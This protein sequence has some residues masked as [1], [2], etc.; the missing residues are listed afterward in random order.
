[1]AP[2]AVKAS[3]G[4][5]SILSIVSENNLA[6][7]PIEWIP[8]ASTPAKEPGPTALI[9]KI[10]TIISGKTRITLRLNL[11]VPET[12]RRRLILVAAQKAKG[13]HRKAEINVPKIEMTKVSSS[14]RNKSSPAGS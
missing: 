14:P 12:G 11:P 8:S 13:I 7:I 5:V 1:M 3:L 10:A 4:P 6:S 2:A 9:N